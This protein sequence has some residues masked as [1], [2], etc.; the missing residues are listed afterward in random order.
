MTQDNAD[1]NGNET[2]FPAP[3]YDVAEVMMSYM[4]TVLPKESELQEDDNIDDLISQ[5]LFVCAS[6]WNIA[7]LPEDC[8]DLYI[9]Q[10][11]TAYKDGDT[12]MVWDE[13]LEDLLAMSEDM[14]ESFPE[15]DCIITE[16]EMEADEDGEMGFSIGVMPLADAVSMIRDSS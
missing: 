16:H 7:V 5:A 15:G 3:K 11:A 14:K 9:G 12:G 13:L 6:A 1:N 10:M 8:A 4:Y 2:N